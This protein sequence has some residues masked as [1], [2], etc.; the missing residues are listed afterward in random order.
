MTVV[1]HVDDAVTIDIVT[2]RDIPVTLPSVFASIVQSE[3]LQKTPDLLTLSG[4]PKN[5]WSERVKA[6]DHCVNINSGFTANTVIHKTMSLS[7]SLPLIEQRL[8]LP[9]LSSHFNST[10]SSSGKFPR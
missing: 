1:W 3:I 5:C 6:V 9:E 4:P 2:K 8:H 7:K 10:S